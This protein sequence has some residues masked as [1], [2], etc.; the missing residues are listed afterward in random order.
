MPPLPPFASETQCPSPGRYPMRWEDVEHSLV[1][2][3]TWERSS[4]R[5]GLWDEL[6]LHRA[7]VE[8]LFGSVARIWLAGS[9]ISGKLDPSDIDLAYLIDADAYGAVTE[10]DDIADL[11][12]LSD[13]E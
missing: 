7:G 9:F 13:R 11:A 1:R 12:N 3:A 5:Q 6:K 4:T 10:P 8:C 2:A